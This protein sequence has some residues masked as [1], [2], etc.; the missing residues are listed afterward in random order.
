MPVIELDRKTTGDDYTAF[1]GGDNQPD[2]QGSGRMGRQDP[3]AGRRRSR[4]PRRAAEFLARHRAARRLQGGHRRQSEDQARR[5]A[6][7]RLDG[8]QGRDGVLGHAAG[9]S[10]HQARLYEQRSRGVRRLYRGQAG[11]QAGQVKII[12][13]D[14][15]PGPSGGIRSVADGQWAAT[16][17]YPTG[18]AQA[19][20]LAKKILIDCATEVPR[21]VMVP[22]QRIDQTNAKELYGKEQF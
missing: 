12:G 11:G 20:E 1:V 19:L 6:A 9:P 2:R 5:R 13:T 4:D 15:L 7:G 14:G 10:G 17:T 21:N 22:S 8:G 3:A 16:F 18:A